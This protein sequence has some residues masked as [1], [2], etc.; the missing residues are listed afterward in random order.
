VLSYNGK[1]QTVPT[2]IIAGMFGFRDEEFFEA[3]EGAR[4]DVSV[5]F[6]PPA[7]SN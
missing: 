7:P 1:V 2:A 3:E 6:A 4:D 5:S